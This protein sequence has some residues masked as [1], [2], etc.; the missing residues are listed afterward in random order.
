VSLPPRHLLFKVQVK[1][2]CH[3]SS[4]YS[5]FIEPKDYHHHHHVLLRHNGSK[6]N[7]VE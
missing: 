4:V 2:C 7:T 6:N 1:F 3:Y 5:L